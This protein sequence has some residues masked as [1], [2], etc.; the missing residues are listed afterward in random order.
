VVDAL[1]ADLQRLG[2]AIKPLHDGL[3]RAYVRMSYV[4]A[5]MFTD[6]LAGRT[7]GTI[8]Q[9]LTAAGFETGEPR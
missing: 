9:Y 7:P 6:M 2:M 4:Q 8:R 5:A 3:I 1:A